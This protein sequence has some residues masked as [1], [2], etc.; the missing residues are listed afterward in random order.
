MTMTEKS[1]T[2]RAL[3]STYKYRQQPDRFEWL[4]DP[5]IKELISDNDFDYMGF[6]DVCERL[7]ISKSALAKLCIFASVAS[8]TNAPCKPLA[9]FSAKLDTS[10][11][12]LEL[13]YKEHWHVTE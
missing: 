8:V 7:E 6:A 2:Q 10:A 11:H 12:L 9:L 3:D 13:Y 1:D 4:F 5:V